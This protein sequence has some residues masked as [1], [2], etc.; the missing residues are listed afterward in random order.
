MGNLTKYIV[1]FAVISGALVAIGEL[2]N[3]ITNTMTSSLG[4][5]LNFVNYLNPFVNP[6]TLLSVLQVLINYFLALIVFRIS[7]WFVKLVAQ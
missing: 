4:F 2:T 3:P 7:I 6:S 5:L 1:L